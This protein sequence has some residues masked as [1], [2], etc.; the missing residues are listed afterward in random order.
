MK[1]LPKN[2]LASFI[3]LILLAAVNTNAAPLRNVPQKIT[4]PNGVTVECFASGDEF[5]NWLHCENGY[6]IVQNPET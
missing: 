1:N 2:L 3:L 4:Q 5:Y 6:T